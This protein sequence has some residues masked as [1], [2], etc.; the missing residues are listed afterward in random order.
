[1]SALELAKVRE[2]LWHNCS[3][4]CGW[5]A[6]RLYGGANGDLLR[7]DS[8]ATPCVPGLLQ[9][10]PLSPRQTTAHLYFH[11]SPQ[12]LTGRSGSVSCGVTAPVPGSSA[13]K[14]FAFGLQASLAALK[15]DSKHDFAPPTILKNIY[16][17]FVDYVKA[18]V[19]ITANCGKFFKRWEYQTT[20]PA[21]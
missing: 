7:E 14:G 6:R 15:F 16:F 4:I 11:W 1:M 9:P 8:C 13:H 2:L 5:S 17:C 3:P 18:F 19:W 20:L 10:E 12:T 21:S